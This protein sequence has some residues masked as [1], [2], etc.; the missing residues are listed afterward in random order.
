MEP[1]SDFTIELSAPSAVSNQ[2]FSTSSADVFLPS[3]SFSQLISPIFPQSSSTTPDELDPSTTIS[4][5]FSSDGKP[6]STDNQTGDAVKPQ[7]L[8]TVPQLDDEEP[9][10][11]ASNGTDTSTTNPNIQIFPNPS[12]PASSQSDGELDP[13]AIS[14]DGLAP[15]T[16][17][18]TDASDSDPSTS[19]ANS[20]GAAGQTEAEP[21]IIVSPADDNKSTASPSQGTAGTVPSNPAPPSSVSSSAQEAELPPFDSQSSTPPSDP[22]NPGSA[23]QDDSTATTS[24]QPAPQVPGASPAESADGRTGANGAGK[25][26]GLP[27]GGDAEKA[28]QTVEVRI[29]RKAATLPKMMDVRSQG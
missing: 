27:G 28:L 24:G 3:S 6:L 12:P 10:P 8:V 21:P 4:I 9:S 29:E 26:D 16:G 25:G 1:S 23:V 14:L 13:L 18:E 15:G 22:G 2:A 11:Q 17:L 19:S 7:I 20:S 5:E